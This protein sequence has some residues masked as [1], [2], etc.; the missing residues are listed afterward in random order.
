MPRL[1]QKPAK[2][3]PVTHKEADLPASRGL[4]EAVRQELK[5]DNRQRR[6][7]MRSEFAA[8]DAKLEKVLTA[9]SQMQIDNEKQRGDNKI[10]LEALSGLASRQDRVESEVREIKE[11]VAAIAKRKPIQTKGSA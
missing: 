1:T 7:E 11:T 5:A 2:K 8:L 3:S 9:V 4:I 6:A 10:V